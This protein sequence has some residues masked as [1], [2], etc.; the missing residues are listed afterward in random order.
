M[1]ISVE[2][3]VGVHLPDYGEVCVHSEVLN[4]EDDC[5]G[6]GRQVVW[7]D[8]LRARVSSPGCDS[9]DSRSKPVVRLDRTKALIFFSYRRPKNY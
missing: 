3:P 4:E 2:F 8:N 7:E 5:I 1:L 6:A 9:D